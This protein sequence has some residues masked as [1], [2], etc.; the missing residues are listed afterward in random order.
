[1]FKFQPI[2]F[3][4]NYFCKHMYQECPVWPFLPIYVFTDWSKT[5]FKHIKYK[6]RKRCDSC[7]CNFPIRYVNGCP[8]SKIL[9]LKY[10]YLQLLI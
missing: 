7:S 8:E 5:V 10:P 6:K 2:F 3:L 4:C 9:S 1:M